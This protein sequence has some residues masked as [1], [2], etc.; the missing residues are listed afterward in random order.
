[1]KSFLSRKLS[2]PTNRT[3]IGGL[4]QGDLPTTMTIKKPRVGLFSLITY[5]K[6]PPPK[7]NSRRYSF[8][9]LYYHK[10]YLFLLKVLGYPICETDTHISG[11]QNLKKSRTGQ[12][13]FF[14]LLGSNLEVRFQLESYEDVTLT[15]K[16]TIHLKD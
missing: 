9:L 15:R 1:M 8:Y 12:S 6:D 10:T 14:R 2:L 11:S 13:N 3:I 5:K 7:K 4:T 16:M